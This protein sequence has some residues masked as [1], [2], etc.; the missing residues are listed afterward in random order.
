LFIFDYEITEIG[1]ALIPP[2]ISSLGG[3]SPS[4]PEPAISP[5]DILDIR[6]GKKFLYFLGWARYYDVF[7]NTKQHIT[8]FGWNITPLGDPLAYVPVLP[9][10]KEALTFPYLF[11]KKG[12]CADDECE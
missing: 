4:A 12:N 10:Q 6:A 3:V 5:Q 2:K 7:P 9:G 8:R 11:L 1:T